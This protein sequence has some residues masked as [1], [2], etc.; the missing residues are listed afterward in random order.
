MPKT[1]LLLRH[2]T[3]DHDTD[4]DD[5]GRPLT[6]QGLKDCAVMATYLRKNHL[7]P[8]LVLCSDALRTT[9]TAQNVLAPLLPKPIVSN[10]HDLYLAT[11]G[12]ILKVLATVPDHIQIVLVVAH[13]PG[14]QQLA[15][16]LMGQH[17]KNASE[18]YRHYPT[19]GL[20]HFSIHASS[21]Q[22]LDASSSLFNDFTYPKMLQEKR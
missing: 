16:F 18:L 3:S 10:T 13:H 4:A 6:P 20:A 5:A 8:Q 21:W 11:A 15:L 22:Q 1:L 17:Q 14:L 9:Q 2:A 12:E 19:T 7:T